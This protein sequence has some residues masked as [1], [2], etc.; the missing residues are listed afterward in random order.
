MISES[1][2]RRW[3]TCRRFINKA[4]RI[5]QGNNPTESEVE[6]YLELVAAEI[7][8]ILISRRYAVPVPEDAAGALQLLRGINIHG[9]EVMM[10]EASESHPDLASEQK[11]YE[12]DLKMLR[13]SDTIMEIPKNTQRASARGP[14]VTVAPPSTH[15]RH[16]ARLF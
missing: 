16:G 11:T 2:M 7:D 14:G 5:G 15:T 10:E 4:R 13:E 6:T 8:G 1:D 9:A 3:P 12:A